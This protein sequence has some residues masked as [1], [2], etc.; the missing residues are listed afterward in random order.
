MS[1]ALIAADRPNFD[2]LLTNIIDYV[3]NADFNDS[4]LAMETARYCFMDSVA[5]AL[6]ALKYPACTKMLGPFVEG[7]DMPNGGSKVPGTRYQL[8]PIQAAFNFGAMI[9]WLDFNDTWLAKEWGHPSDNLGSILMVCDYLNRQHRDQPITMKTVLKAMIMA[10]EI[11]G[12]LAIGNSFNL[13]G[14]DHVLLVRVASTA[15]VSKLMGLNRD[16]A[17]NA[18]SNAWLDG[19][20]LRTYRHAPNAGSRKS[21][22]AGDATSRA[23][24]LAMIARTGEM[25]YPSAISAPVWGFQDVSFAKKPVTLERK[26]GSYVM[27]NV[28]FK[29]SF[30]AE[31][32]A[33]TAVE[34]AI[35]LHDQVK[36]RFDDINKIIIETQESGDRIINKTGRLDNPA[37]RDHCIQYMTAIGLMKGSLTAEDYEDDVAAIPLVDELR[38][39]MEV[40]ENKDYSREY[41]D[42]NKRSIANSVQVIFN[43]GEET[44]KVE[45]RY[46]IGHRVRREEGIPVLVNKFHQALSESNIP[47]QQISD[48]KQLCDDHASFLSATVSTVT[49]LLHVQTK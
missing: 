27:E 14:L 48:L 4:S 49:D 2:P 33:Q 1:N 18:L 45:V 15:V 16:Q 12:V 21:W 11:Q 43:N 29:I 35:I 10:H 34:A 47:H 37:D 41:L 7:G 32:H 6:M 22:A 8:D 40:I 17:L 31:F 44:E 38:S 28:L 5:C 39:H 24:R 23:V 26:L 13:V 46:P 20:S 19:S 25:G 9:R 30:P 3:M 42:L 36:H